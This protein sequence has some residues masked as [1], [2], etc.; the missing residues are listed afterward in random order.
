MGDDILAALALVMVIEGLLP[1]LAPSLY[2]RT[3]SNL[4]QMPPASLRQFGVI[5]MISGAVLLYLIRH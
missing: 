2:Q 1:A 3:M 4:A 5:S